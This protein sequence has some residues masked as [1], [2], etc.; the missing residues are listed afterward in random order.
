M[1]VI[2]KLKEKWKK[3]TTSKKPFQNSGDYW[4]NRY[5]DGGNS[6]GG[7]YGILAEF[8]ARVLNN[9]IKK[10]NIKTVIEFGCG[11]GN[12]LTLAE[13]P[14]YI[15]FDVSPTAIS[16]CE[17]LFNNDSS[18]SFMLINKYKDQN[19]DVTLSLDVIFHLVEDQVFN[20]YMERLFSA[21]NKYVII[22]SSNSDTVEAPNP[23]V[24]HR[25]F[26][27]WVAANQSDWKLLQ[28]IPNENPYTGNNKMSSFADFYI[29]AKI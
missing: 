2:S 26:T 24:R 27:N 10:E 23:H 13:Y 11:D 9:F 7:S 16:L 17:S 5:N 18:K 14:N 21:S 12:Q 1:R 15:G 19:A 22:F 29:F 28:H 20:E 4:I 6:G 3:L 8:K 25:K